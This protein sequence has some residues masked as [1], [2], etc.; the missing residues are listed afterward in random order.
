[1]QYQIACFHLLLININ[2]EVN[3]LCELSKELQQWPSIEFSKH[4]RENQ[5]YFDH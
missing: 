1:M 3:N 2:T 4:N 5:K